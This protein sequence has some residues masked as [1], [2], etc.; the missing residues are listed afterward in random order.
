ML[1]PKCNGVQCLECGEIVYYQ[2][3]EVKKT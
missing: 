1:C 2:L 3:I